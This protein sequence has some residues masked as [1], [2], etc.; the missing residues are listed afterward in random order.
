MPL[1]E[2]VRYQAAE[3]VVRAL[4]T[5]E[6]AAARLAE[7]HLAAAV[8]LDANGVAITDRGRVVDG[9]TGQ[10]AFTP[11]FAQGE[12]SLPEAADGEVVVTAEF[13]GLGAAPR[14]Y[15][16]AFSFDA[17]DRITRIEERQ[18]RPRPSCSTWDGARPALG[19]PGC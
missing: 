12:W 13:P 17:A 15:R 19:R 2:G 4:R 14:S 7:S 1:A 18:T 16:L 5:G 8:T 9:L 6:A 11:V 10:W 3:A